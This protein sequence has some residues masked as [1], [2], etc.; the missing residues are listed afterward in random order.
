MKDSY[1]PLDWNKGGSKGNFKHY[2]S[3]DYDNFAK[4]PTYRSDAL[5]KDEMLNG[6]FQV[7]GTAEAD[8]FTQADY[9]RY[10]QN[11]TYRNDYYKDAPNLDDV[12]QDGY[13]DQNY[14]NSYQDGYYDQ[15]YDNG[16]QDGYYDQSYD[17]GYQDGY[18]DQSYDN[19]Y[20]DGYYDQGYNNSYQQPTST[21]SDP[22]MAQ[23]PVR[24]SQA[25]Y[26]QM[27][28]HPTYTSSNPND[29]GEE[30]FFN[31]IDQQKKRE[32]RRDMIGDLALSGTIFNR[33]AGESV[34]IGKDVWLYILML[35][36]GA[37]IARLFS[38]PFCIY[39]VFA[40]FIALVVTFIKKLVI[41]STPKEDVFK[42]CLIPG[43]IL[44]I[45]IGVSVYM[46]SRGL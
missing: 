32:R 27:A 18:Y 5:T 8:S 9:D 30:A 17:N 16:Y 20:Q 40:A 13:Y 37:A 38:M 11:P 36:F 42:E 29:M 28:Q 43:V 23:G 19:G 10:A 12:Y 46:H 3:T 21:Y 31:M 39:P 33:H 2:S 45:C 6:G 34:E 22:Q 14:D 1:D 4:N 35:A 15:S 41:D 25:D 26:D 7:N 24:Y 44:G